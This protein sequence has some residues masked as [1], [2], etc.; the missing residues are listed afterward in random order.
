MRQALL[1]ACAANAPRR[2]SRTGPSRSCSRACGGEGVPATARQRTSASKEPSTPTLRPPASRA[3]SSS[4]EFANTGK[5]HHEFAMGRLAPGKTFED[6]RRELEDGGEEGPSSSVDVGGVPLLSPG[7]EVTITRRL[8][9][10]HARPRLLR[11]HPPA[12]TRTS[13]RAWWG[14]SWSRETQAPGCRRQTERSSPARTAPD[15][16]ELEAGTKTIELRNDASGPREFNLL[17][18]NPGKT[19]ADAEKWFESGS[20]GP[21]TRLRRRDAV[22][23]GRLVRLPDASTSSQVSSTSC[24]R[25]SRATAPSSP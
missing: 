2:S 25:R 14:A 7:E 21:P 19:I 13:T 8:E 4:M 23:P 10:R 12:A 5:R 9:P 1:G 18:L 16:P 3:V 20:E 17:R 6:F 11:A 24:S 22:D 15:V